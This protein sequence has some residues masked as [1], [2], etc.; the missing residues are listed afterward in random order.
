[1]KSI[2]HSYFWYQERGTQAFESQS[3]K[4]PMLKKK[5]KVFKIGKLQAQRCLQQC[6]IFIKNSDN[7]LNVL[8]RTCS[9]KL[10]HPACPAASQ[11]SG[12]SLSRA[13][14]SRICP[15]PLAWDLAHGRGLN[16]FCLRCLFF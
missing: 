5:K 13:S 9:R 7:Y 15:Q 6:Y 10:C 1:M 11:S 4:S 14:L 2:T 16:L 8:V 3:S 12:F